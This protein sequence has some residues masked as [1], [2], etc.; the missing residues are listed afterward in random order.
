[1]KDYI[2][3]IPVYRLSR[4]EYEKSRQENT[5]KLLQE[6]GLLGRPSDQKDR[7]V[8][9]S[10]HAEMQFGGAWRFNEI[11]YWIRIVFL[12]KNQIRGELW[13]TTANKVIKTRKK[14]FQYTTYSFGTPIDITYTKTNNEIFQKMCSYINDC[15]KH[16]KLI[17]RYFDLE[18]FEKL[19]PHIDWIKLKA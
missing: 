2:F 14:V 12:G 5:N 7:I 16:P 13:S 18:L 19:G 3:D 11:V 4:E 1:M 9:I 6:A 10:D 8:Q 17:K 15:K